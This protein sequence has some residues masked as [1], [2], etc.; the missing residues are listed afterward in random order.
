MP[1]SYLTSL[2][3][4]CFPNS[5]DHMMKTD[6]QNLPYTDTPGCVCW[7]GDRYHLSDADFD[8]THLFQANS[9]GKWRETSLIAHKICFTVSSSA[10]FSPPEATALWFL[11]HA[12]VSVQEDKPFGILLRS[13]A[14]G[15]QF[16]GNPRETL[17]IVQERCW[18]ALQL[19]WFKT[20]TPNVETRVQISAHTGLEV[21]ETKN[22]NKK[23]KRKT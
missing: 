21:C 1:R 7:P 4:Y 15:L 9:A 11:L 2:N 16:F 23:N 13:V 6:R 20:V 12:G 5:S 14:A 10:I 18:V 19:F 8:W 3:K 17:E 22:R